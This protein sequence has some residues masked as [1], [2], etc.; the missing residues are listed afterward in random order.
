M[1]KYAAIEYSRDRLSEVEFCNCGFN[2]YGVPFHNMNATLHY[3]EIGN[4]VCLVSYN[5][6]AAFI[7]TD[8]GKHYIYYIKSS[9]TTEKQITRFFY[10]NGINL[11]AAK[12]KTPNQWIQID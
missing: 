2:A 11:P 12:R 5:T 8:N 7:D 9:P 4:C 6:P 1:Y 3:M 10:E